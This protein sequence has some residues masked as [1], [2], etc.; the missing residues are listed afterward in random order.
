[1]AES[2]K[3]IHYI[4]ST[5]ID[6]G[7]DL[8]K[9]FVVVQHGG[10][11]YRQSY[12]KV[13]DLF[14]KFVNKTI[15]QCPDLLGLGAKNEM[16]VYYPIDVDHEWLQPNYEQQDKVITIGHFPRSPKIKGTH[17]ILQA[18]NILEADKT[19]NKKFK[20][21]GIRTTAKKAGR[22]PWKEHLQRVTKCDIIIETCNTKIGKQTYGEWANTALEGAALGKIVI[23][24]TLAY[25]TYLKEYG[26]LGIRVANRTEGIIREIKALANM[27]RDEIAAE[28]MKTRLWV[29]KNHSLQANAKRL[30]EKI[31]T[32]GWD[33]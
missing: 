9:K 8:S 23:S 14:N 1:M 22:L 30:K 19:V 2:A 15:I 7:V 3:A 32:E 28:K 31:Y 13:N 33:K 18:I 12:G 24:N 29:E 10:S 25:K 27:S 4:A 26:E 16:L 17:N 11:K 5:Y 6:T 20:Y 21:V